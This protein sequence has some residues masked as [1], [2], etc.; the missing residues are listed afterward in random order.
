MFLLN[1][2]AKELKTRILRDEKDAFNA[3]CNKFKFTKC[4]FPTRR[5][6]LWKSKDG[7]EYLCEGFIV[8][9]SDWRKRLVHF[10]TMPLVRHYNGLFVFI[11]TNDGNEYILVSPHAFKRYA[12]RMNFEGSNIDIVMTFFKRNTNFMSAIKTT[13]RGVEQFEFRVDDGF[14]FLS[15]LEE[16]ISTAKT[17]VT[18][19][20]LKGEQKDRSEQMDDLNKSKNE[21]Y[22]KIIRQRYNNQ[23]KFSFL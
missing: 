1:H 9:K 22:M 13:H 16:G 12:E 18:H 11:P 15:E 4:A 14:F 23:Q 20:M 21:M 7:Y 6:Y 8:S 19:D 2:T 5:L 10:F 17:F 3:F